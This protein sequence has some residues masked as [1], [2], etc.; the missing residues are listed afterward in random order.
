V[1]TVNNPNSVPVEATVTENGLSD[2]TA[3]TFDACDAATTTA[4]MAPGDNTF[5]YT[6]T[7][8]DET[9]S[10]PH[11]I[12]ND[13]ALT[14]AFQTS[15]SGD[16]DTVYVL[17]PS[18]APITASAPIVFTGSQVDRCIT[19][20]DTAFPAVNGARFCA[21][22][23]NTSV[24]YTIVWPVPSAGCVNHTN[25]ASFVT[26]DTG[27]TGASS[28]TVRICRTP[29]VTGAR[30]IGFWKNKNGQRII[31]GQAKTGVCPST[32]WLRGYAPFKDLGSSAT[33]A[34]VGKYV[35][36]VLAAATAQGPSM[37]AMLKAQMLAT[38]LDVYFSNGSLGGNKLGA[39]SPI[40]ARVI[41]LTAPF[42]ASAAF[43][44]DTQDTV[45]A[46][47]SI[48]AAH[49]NAGGSSWYAQVKATQGLA[50]DTFDNINNEVAYGF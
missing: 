36:G 14:W 45:S 28:A 32:A 44:G 39:P 7:Y 19:L 24:N 22:D 29:L 50:K 6:C 3:C 11:G 26:D 35:N 34:T 20:A 15:V 38:A 23:L 16:G 37:N 4:T 21:G 27:A 25:T 30:T 47:L 49:S 33:C 12:T 8:P 46:L 1:V 43:D 10:V 40:G 17:D 41:D 31:T 48:A 9:A 18:D 13:A 2:G 5:A 42:D